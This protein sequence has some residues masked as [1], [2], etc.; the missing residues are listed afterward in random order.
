MSLG[1]K[2]TVVIPSDFAYGDQGYPG[3]IPGGAYIAFDI[4]VVKAR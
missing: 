2:R 3:V 4:E 1:E